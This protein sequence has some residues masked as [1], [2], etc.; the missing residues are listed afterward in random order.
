MAVKP[1]SKAEDA[2][3][4]MQVTRLQSN[5]V[6]G[7]KI[8][9]MSPLIYNSVSLKAQQALLAPGP[10]K[11]DAE[12]KAKEKHDPIW[13]YRNSVYRV[14][15]DSHQTRLVLPS[16]MVKAA[17]RTAALDSP[18]V[19]KTA[20]GR[21]IW[22][23]GENVP[24]WGV[25][26]LLMSVVRSAD[27][28]RTPDIRTRAYVPEWATTVSIRFV[29]PLLRAKSVVDLLEAAG[30]V[31]GVGD[32]RQEKGAGSY[33]MFR[34]VME[35]DE[36]DMQDWARIVWN[37]GRLAQD[38]ALLDPSYVDQGTHDLMDWFH[39]EM[40]LRGRTKDVVAATSKTRSGNTGARIN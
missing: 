16:K 32:Y 21:L 38:A 30:M 2:S 37:G 34:I 40:K 8:I 27:M 33:G 14:I 39:E 3:P 28:K 23:E 17:M 20:I 13:E 35:N 15:G 5:V 1:T 10:R 19:T 11:N 6:H 18:G 26:Q 25:P 22:V 29:T 9:G 4:E 12:K 7:I 36:K 24:L 31:A